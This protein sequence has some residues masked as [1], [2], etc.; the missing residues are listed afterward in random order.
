MMEPISSM[1]TFSKRILISLIAVSGCLGYL[2]TFSYTHFGIPC[3]FRLITGWL[4][5]GCGITHMLAYIICGEYK[6][7]FSENA[8]LFITSPAYIYICLK[9][10]FCW[11][12]AKEAQWS[13]WENVLIYALLVTAIIFGIGRNLF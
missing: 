10:W 6:L 2:L 13:I 4:C 11:V 5:P 3:L 9:M 1:T 12:Q 8:Y 7:A